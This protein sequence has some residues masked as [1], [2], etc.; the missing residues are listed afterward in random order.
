LHR[1]SGAAL[2]AGGKDIDDRNGKDVG[3][4]RGGSGKRA[5]T[6]AARGLGF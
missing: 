1:V 6:G 5:A 4:I 2:M 3:E